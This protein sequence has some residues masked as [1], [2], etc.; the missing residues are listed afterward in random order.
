MPNDGSLRLQSTV[1]LRQLHR[2]TS[3]RSPGVP[4][5]TQKN[6]RRCRGDL[7]P[8][9]RS[10]SCSLRNHP[11]GPV[12]IGGQEYISSSGVTERTANR[13][14]PWHRAREGT[15]V[16]HFLF[17]GRGPSQPCAELPGRSSLSE[18]IATLSFAL[19]LADYA[20]PGSPLRSRRD[21]RLTGVA[22]RFFP[23]APRVATR[24]ESWPCGT[25]RCA[26]GYVL[27][28]RRQSLQNLE[29]GTGPCPMPTLTR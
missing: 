17:E 13:Y 22:F 19:G 2:I 4:L 14:P 16:V 11:R 21:Q 20:Q 29:R 28:G 6:S 18:A 1:I 3:E 7:Q 5:S 9:P 12:G 27:D 15:F 23:S 10:S 24:S 8:P 26:P 25:S